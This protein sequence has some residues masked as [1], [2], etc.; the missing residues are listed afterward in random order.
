MLPRAKPSPPALTDPLLT[1]RNELA[2][3]ES[4]VAAAHD[5]ATEAKQELRSG[6]AEMAQICA[7]TR[8]ELEEVR[9]VASL[10][11]DALKTEAEVTAGNYEYS[12]ERMKG[13]HAT[14]VEQLIEKDSRHDEMDSLVQD[15]TAANAA[16]TTSLEDLR[17]REAAIALRL[18][19]RNSAA[20]SLRA[21]APVLELAAE[22]GFHDPLD[23]VDGQT[24]LHHACQLVKSPGEQRARGAQVVL[25]LCG[26]F[27]KNL[28]D[29][30]IQQGWIK[31]YTALHILA[32]GNTK[33]YDQG[34]LIT[35]LLMRQADVNPRDLTE[36]TPLLKACGTGNEDA[37]GALLSFGADINAVDKTGR[38][39][40]D[41]CYRNCGAVLQ[42]L[43]PTMFCF[44]LRHFVYVSRPC[45]VDL[46]TG[47]SRNC[48]VGV[49]F[50]SC[51]WLC[52]CLCICA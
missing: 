44:G 12:L 34:S 10:R 15:L 9:E 4:Q 20:S 33:K 7:D 46:L 36:R 30:P 42:I 51:F 1:L 22:L 17:A 18:E 5:E 8:S 37:V 28:L 25:G 45:Y 32:N 26:L 19:E 11:V 48:I 23:I 14:Y 3:L 2:A 24:L 47:R 27:P 39:V 16:L 52:I 29:Y 13:E 50:C 38:G 35:S 6:E 31:G 40:V 43:P 21:P 49:F 41:K